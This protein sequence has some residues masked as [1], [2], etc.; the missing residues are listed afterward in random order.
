MRESRFWALVK[1]KLPGHVERVENA[2]AKGTPDVNMCFEGREIWLE[3]KVLDDKG[4]LHRDDPRPEQLIWHMKRQ[5]NGGSCFILGR[6]EKVLKIFQVQ[7]DR[8]LF[9]LWTCTK[10]FHWSIFLT[11]LFHTPAFCSELELPVI[12]E[13][14]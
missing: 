10:P 14:Q 8:S 11:V 2:I 12:G 3:L 6:N 4:R 1:D 13:K 5:I 7:R 9:E